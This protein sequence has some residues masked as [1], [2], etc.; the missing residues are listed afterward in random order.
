MPTLLKLS[1]FMFTMLIAM[2]GSR[3]VA[4]AAAPSDPM[5]DYFKQLRKGAANKD[6]KLCRFLTK[7]EVARYLGEPV[8]DGSPGGSGCIWFA[9]T[10]SDQVT[11]TRAAGRDTVTT[12]KNLLSIKP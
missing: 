12:P 7:D 5:T 8:R 11:V 4:L 1:C 6:P 2:S 3:G 10:G 9:S